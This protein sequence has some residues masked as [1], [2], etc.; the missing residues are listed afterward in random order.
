MSGACRFTER[1]EMSRVYFHTADGELEIGGR[2]RRHFGYLCW[3]M[4]GGIIDIDR[5]HRDEL[6]PRLRSMLRPDHYAVDERFFDDEDRFARTI[7]TSLRVDDPLQW[8]GHPIDSLGLHLNTAIALGSDA[9]KFTARIHGQCE[10]YGFVEG[11]N[12]GWLAYVIETGLASGVFHSKIGQGDHEWSDVVEMLRRT[13][14]GAV[15]MSY[16]VCSPFPYGV[17][18]DDERETLTGPLR[19]HTGL[20]RI[21][22]RRQGLE[23]CPDDWD[24]FRFTHRLSALD[25]VAEDW[26]ER[27]DAALPKAP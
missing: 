4:F 19:W 17:L 9:V 23:L 13:A 12:R 7:S 3:R 27:L 8:N 1:S 15:V 21:R 11:K 26:R 10:I 22:E 24:T 2:E 18:D 5:S 20:A 6:L 16:S 14:N 25:L